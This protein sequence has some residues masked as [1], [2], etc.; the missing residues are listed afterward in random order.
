[1]IINENQLS[2]AHNLLS[3]TKIKI[4]TKNNLPTTIDQNG[5]CWKLAPISAWGIVTLFPADCR[6]SNSS[7][8]LKQKS[9]NKKI[10]KKK[11]RIQTPL[12]NPI[13]DL[14]RS[15]KRILKKGEYI[16]IKCHNIPVDND[17]SF[18]AINLLYYG[19]GLCG[20][21]KKTNYSRS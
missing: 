8:F 2:P 13:I 1:M 21:S 10:D 19:G 12:V 9:F 17:P 4:N 7:Y 14:E 18:S 6:D 15:V 3:R 11:I 16:V 5:Y 20:L